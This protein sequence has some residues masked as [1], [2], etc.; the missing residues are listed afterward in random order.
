MRKS[1]FL[2]LS[3]LLGLLSLS[4]AKPSTHDPY[5]IF[6]KAAWKTSLHW[7]PDM[8]LDEFEKFAWATWDGVEGREFVAEYLVGIAMQEANADHL[9]NIH[10]MGYIGGT[11]PTIITCFKRDGMT[12]PPEGW[13]AWAEKNPY[14]VHKRLSRHFNEFVEKYGEDEAIMRWHRGPGWNKPGKTSDEAKDYLEK[15]NARM[16]Y[17]YDRKLEV[18]ETAE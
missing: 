17:Y 3:L 4:G 9:N 15:I 7:R 2:L 12:R 11:W 10:G 6:L 18:L 13:R 1:L 5:T 14:L 8:P 16:G